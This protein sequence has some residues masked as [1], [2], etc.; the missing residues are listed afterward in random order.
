[1]DWGSPAEFQA[2]ILAAFGAA[3]AAV[4][5]YLARDQILRRKT[6]YDAER[7]ESQRDR[8]REKYESDWGGDEQ[9]GAGGE[10]DAG[11]YEVLG[12]KPG[13]TAEQVRARYRELA[14]ENHPDK[15]G[16]EGAAERMARINAAYEE[17]AG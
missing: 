12:L 13:A 15:D 8:D 4:F 16:S 6:D 7:L 1:M 10:P 17:L 3:A 2:W 9:A 11:P 14:R 5:A